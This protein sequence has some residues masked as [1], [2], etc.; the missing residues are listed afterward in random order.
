M[1][2]SFVFAVALVGSFP[3]NTPTKPAPNPQPADAVSFR[4]P[5]FA[6]A[7]CPIMGKPASASLFT[8]TEFGRIYVCCKPCIKKVRKEAE[9]SW[10]TAYPVVKP[11]TNTACPITGKDVDA[12]VPVVAVQGVS[13]ALCC[14]DCVPKVTTSSQIALAKAEDPKLVDLENRAC[15]ITGEEAD[16]NTIA[17]IDGTIVRFATSKARDAAKEDAKAA[18]EKARTLRQ[19]EIDGTLKLVP[20]P[21]TDARAAD[22]A[23]DEKDDG[24]DAEDGTSRKNS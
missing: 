20:H 16:A 4:V 23:K 15:P 1:I 9:K 17:V 19:Q 6:N 13:I 18:L 8:D 22:E 5:E 21:D 2:A 3:Q 24:R 10:K 14:T 7:T 11:A 12:K